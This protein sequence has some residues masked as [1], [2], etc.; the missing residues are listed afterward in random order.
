MNATLLFTMN[1]INNNEN[2]RNEN[3]F[4]PVSE[5]ETET[6]NENENEI[7]S[8]S[9]SPSNENKTDAHETPDEQ[10]V[11]LKIT[12][13]NTKKI[14]IKTS[15]SFDD[16]LRSHAITK[17]QKKNILSTNT[18]IAGTN[19]NNETIYGGNF[20]IPDSE[21]K[22][23]LDLYFHTIFNKK[24]SYL[25]EAQLENEGPI[26]IDI[27]LRFA[28]DTTERQ[29]TKDHLEDIIEGYLEVL[30]QIYEMDSS[31][32]FSIFIFEKPTI[33]HDQEKK[34]T[35]D[36]IHIIIGIK[37]EHT[38]QQWIRL[39]MKTIFEEKWGDLPIT[40]TW[41]EVLDHGIS[42]GNIN[43]QLTGS[44]KPKNIKYE[45]SLAYNVVFDEEKE[46][47]IKTEIDVAEFLIMPTNFHRLSAR[48]REHPVFLL[49]DSFVEK[50]KKKIESGE[51]VL[52]KKK[53]ADGGN[54]EN[55]GNHA[56]AVVG[57]GGG[58]GGGGEMPR[59]IIQ[60]IAISNYMDTS[61][62][63]MNLLP[64]LFE[65]RNKEE[66][67][68]LLKAF[69]DRH[70]NSTNKQDIEIVESYEFT[71]SLP[72]PY[73][74]EYSKWIRVG[75]ALRNISDKLFFVWFAFSLQ[76]SSKCQMN[77][78]KDSYD[79]WCGFS[80]NPQGLTKRS[81]MHWSKMDAR[82]KYDNII[83]NSIESAME[84]TLKVSTDP[85]DKS[86]DRG[87]AD[88]DL[89]SVLYQLFKDRFVCVGIK[90]NVW[91][92]YTKHRWVENDSGTTLRLAISRDMRDV[93]QQKN[94]Y[95]MDRYT[96]L[97]TG[98]ASTSQMSDEEKI[99][100]QHISKRKTVRINDIL[101][102][103][104]R[105]NDKKNI[106][107]EAKELF[108]DPEFMAKLDTNPYLLCFK[109]GVVDFKNKVFRNGLPEDY[110]SRTTKIDYIE[111]LNTTTHPAIFAEITDFMQ[112]LFPIKELHDY[113]WEH[114]AST[115]IGTS[116]NQTFNMYIGVGQNG[117]SVLVSLMES[118]LGD[119]KGDVPLSLVT[120]K[121][122]KIGGLAPETV[123]LRGI[124]YA[125]MQEP[126]KGDRINEGVMKQLTSGIDPIQARAPYMTSAITFIPQFKL[127][128][129]SN[130][131][132][133]IKSQDHGTWRRIRVVDFMSLFVEKPVQNDREKPYQFLLDKS[134]KEKFVY[135]KEVFAHMLVKK[136]YETDGIVKDCSIVMKSSNSY[137]ENQ[138]YIAEFVSDRILEK[139]GGTIAKTELTA[140]FKNWYLGSY[141]TNPPS[142]KEI[143]LYMDRKYGAYKL[144]KCWTNVVINYQ[145][146]SMKMFQGDDD[147]DEEVEDE[148]IEA[149]G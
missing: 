13:K 117:K 78:M 11:S 122:T 18:R 7:N 74:T 77:D 55:D 139:P 21:Y 28:F 23:F 14:S 8:S 81:I 37:C 147:D 131:F 39:K 3:T 94:S 144:N 146:D 72:E 1:A 49:K 27:D 97:K 25:T 35:K 92:E 66:F 73:Y 100:E 56:A 132:M 140:E 22:T 107:T 127:V 124:R 76:C 88:F 62:C 118:V 113:M 26:L 47:L 141:G 119:Y 115:L 149:S 36:G 90:S 84:L 145:S 93:Y 57:G 5:T 60:T 114:L 80:D 130:E 68:V 10:P 106:M 105:T 15:N 134:I 103:L 40:N 54:N 123:A 98:H 48:Y 83:K 136:A 129:C 112:K 2:M 110:V 44:K 19:E 50:R 6:E 59:A 138:D 30:A 91:F 96:K 70:K 125:V 135:W 101:M 31:I 87:V 120:D 20:H 52:A 29:Y 128:V 61:V 34:I 33:V 85:E 51:I 104:G 17:E 53:Q 142:P 67:D 121:R 137:R 82:E 108:H 42:I 46:Q 41:D 16:F 133:E 4:T 9:P 79:K 86:M 126:S 32:A 109:N 65:T 12:K 99:R 38:T 148:G 143:Q 45:L 58:G 71:M 24:D 102:R 95:Y 43:W 111:T 75:W 89:A 116:T 69:I 63:C 64:M